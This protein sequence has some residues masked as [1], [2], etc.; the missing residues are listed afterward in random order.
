[1]K[2]RISISFI[3]LL[4]ILSII[5]SGCANMAQ[6]E[7]SEPRVETAVQEHVDQENVAGTRAQDDFYEYVNG[8]IIEEKSREPENQGWDHFASLY[9]RV[10]DDLNIIAE[11]LKS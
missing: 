7:T 3:S 8:K 9:D 4:V 5:L 10:T 2:R 1:M 6:K 11:E